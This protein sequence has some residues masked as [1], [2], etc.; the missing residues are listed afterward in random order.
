MTIVIAVLIAATVGVIVGRRSKHRLIA[1]LKAAVPA[2]T[3]G[4]PECRTESGGYACSR[5]QGHAGD[6]VARRH[7]VQDVVH[8]W[9]R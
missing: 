4:Y 6:H 5:Q 3:L 1:T 8:V 7:G 9:D 2:K